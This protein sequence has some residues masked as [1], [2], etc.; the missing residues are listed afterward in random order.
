MPLAQVARSV[1]T[2]G[3][4]RPTPEVNR[5]FQ[6]SPGEAKAGL[7][8][9]CRQLRDELGEAHR[10]EASQRICDRIQQWPGFPSSAIVFTYL[11]MRGEVDLRP[12]IAAAPAIRWAIP[13]V[14][15]APERDLVFHEYDPERL[16][17]HRFGMLEPDSALPVVEPMQAA[18]ILVPGLAFTRAGYRLGYGGGYY[19]R[20][21]SKPGHA[22]TL[23]VCLQALLLSEIP[24]EAHDIPV[25]Y[26]VTEE[27]RVMPAQAGG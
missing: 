27:E 22:P 3:E 5:S 2:I 24:H 7:R 23:G 18:L 13:R 1:C 8:A 15:E 10:D 12:L 19:D 4:M 16:V 11:P 20:L 21:L 17:R 26:I 14:V 25:D 6:K 9:C